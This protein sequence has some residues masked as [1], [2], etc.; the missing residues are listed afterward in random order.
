M[1]DAE[2]FAMLLLATNARFRIG[3]RFTT[4]NQTGYEIRPECIL[5]G[6][7][8]I[9]EA[10]Q[11]VL[12]ENGLPVQNQFTDTVHLQKMLR[13]TKAWRDFTKEPDGWLLVARFNGRVP[14]LKFHEDVERALEVF[15]DDA[16]AL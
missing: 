9:P 15:G 8:A 6:R 3:V 16:D 14:E 11:L 12:K 7:N 1:L 10:V 5:F 2:D 13:I 4:N